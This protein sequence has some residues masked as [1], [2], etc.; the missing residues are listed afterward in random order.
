MK[1]NRVVC[2]TASA[3]VRYSYGSIVFA[4]VYIERYIL[5]TDHH[6]YELQI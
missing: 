5:A 6:N 2:Q 1:E 3:V 4:Y